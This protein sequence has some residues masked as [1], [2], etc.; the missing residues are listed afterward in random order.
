MAISGRRKS[1]PVKYKNKKTLMH[2][3]YMAFTS[4]AALNR[5]H[6]AAFDSHWKHKVLASTDAFFRTSIGLLC[7]DSPHKVSMCS[8]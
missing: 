2:A 6:C 1:L 7:K 8:L 5:C 4:H 3:V